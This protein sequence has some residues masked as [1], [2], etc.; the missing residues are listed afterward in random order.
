MKNNY[1]KEKIAAG[2]EQEREMLKYETEKSEKLPALSYVR[3]IFFTMLLIVTLIALA[4]SGFTAIKFF[5]PH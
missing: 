1:L 2:F 4:V 5:M 3:P